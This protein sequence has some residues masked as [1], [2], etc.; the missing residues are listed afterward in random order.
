MTW[1]RRIV[2]A[3]SAGRP[4]AGIT[5]VE[6][7]VAMVLVGVVGAIVLAA[8]ISTQRTVRVAEDETQG[9][10]DVATVVDRLSRDIRSARGVVCDGGS[11]DSTCR[12]HLQL[13]IDSDSDYQQDA[14]EIVR[15]ELKAVDEFGHH[16]MVRSVGGGTPQVM[17]RTIVSDVAFNYKHGDTDIVP[18]P[19]QPLPGEVAAHLVEVSMDYNAVV[20][21]NESNEDEYGSDNRTVRFDTRLRNVA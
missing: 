19:N 8:T 10:E 20:A 14:G 11:G 13:W 15:W 4:D 1:M 9:Q 2:T 21:F 12:K 3:R 17:A 16:D 6:S 18:G 5:L 7:L